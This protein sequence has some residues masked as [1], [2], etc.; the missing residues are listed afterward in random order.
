MRSSTPRTNPRRAETGCPREPFFASAKLA[1]Q[2]ETNRPI[3]YFKGSILNGA[4]PST[5][6][7]QS[8]ISS[9]RWISNHACTSRSCRRGTALYPRT[10]GTVQDRQHSDPPVR[11]HLNLVVGPSLWPSGLFSLQ[12]LIPARGCSSALLLSVHVVHKQFAVERPH[13]ISRVHEVA[14]DQ[15]C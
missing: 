5:A 6:S 1:F 13:S 15:L 3:S 10:S 4:F 11:S 9:S 7:A 14:A 12:P 2:A 8:A